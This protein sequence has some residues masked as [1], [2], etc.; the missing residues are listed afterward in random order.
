MGPGTLSAVRPL[1]WPLAALLAGSLMVP[2]ADAQP[3]SEKARAAWRLEEG[4]RS[5][6]R[7]DADKALPALEEAHMILRLPT[8]GLPL[9]QALAKKGRLADALVVA[10]GVGPATAGKEAF[11]VTSARAQLDK[12]EA[13][14][15]ARVPKLRITA[16][17]GAS[18]T[19]DGRDVPAD[20]GVR[21]VDAG[22]HKVEGK[23]GDA[24]AAAEVTLAEGEDRAVTLDFSRRSAGAEPAAAAGPPTA[25]PAAGAAAPP[26]PASAPEP[27]PPT[28]AV[29]V[30]LAGFTTFAA[31]GGLGVGAFLAGR[32]RLKDLEGACGGSCTG[33]LLRE[34]RDAQGIQLV[35]FVGFGLAGAGLVTG[36]VG[37]VMAGTSG[38]SGE[39]A[40]APELGPGYAGV[41]VRL[42]PGR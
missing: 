27:A 16:P 23:L 9:T 22:S 12:L 26:P 20:A 8:S 6:A 21:R 31:G 37:A 3:Q 13:E 10:R 30:A 11:S 1:A 41:R 35:G 28:G 2:P 29:A 19:I 42:P 32:A 38:P 24:L 14:L 4:K 25:P 5:L 15:D 40:V 17:E 7:G 33:R 18:I 36:I 39:A 34:E